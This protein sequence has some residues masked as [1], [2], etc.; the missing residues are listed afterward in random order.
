[1]LEVYNLFR[2]EHPSLSPLSLSHSFT[3]YEPA[4]SGRTPAQGTF[5][6]SR[7]LGQSHGCLPA[8]GVLF[9]KGRNYL[10]LVSRVREEACL[11]KC[12]LVTVFVDLPS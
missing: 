8:L 10:L 3:T 11:S 1:M 9:S 4:L 5:R 7:A 2:V 6:P 12:S